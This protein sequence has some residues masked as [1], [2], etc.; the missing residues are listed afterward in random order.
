VIA[1]SKDM[2]ELKE[3]RRMRIL[4]YDGY[5]E[6]TTLLEDFDWFREHA[7]DD[8]EQ[9]SRES[10]HDFQGRDLLIQHYEDYAPTDDA[11]YYFELSEDRYKAK[12]IEGRNAALDRAIELDPTNTHYILTRARYAYWLASYRRYKPELHADW[13]KALPDLDYVIAF[14]QDPEEVQDA[15]ELR[16]F[17]YEALGEI[18]KLIHNLSWL[19]DHDDEKSSSFNLFRWRAIHY[20][21]QGRFAEAIADYEQAFHLNPD[22]RYPAVPLK[23]LFLS[24]NYERTIEES[25]K[26]ITSATGRDLLAATLYIR[27]KALHRLGRTAEALIDVQR[28]VELRGKGE[29]V[30]EYLLSHPLDAGLGPKSS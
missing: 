16:S 22:D 7:P 18:D 6:V 11:E 24:G 28:I 21:K 15:Y 25:S 19:I 17:C 3:A 12:D 29:T 10:V 4:S 13:R 27:S 30:E 23:L 1:F 14:S 20:E 8:Y 9:V 26:V 2:A 5:A